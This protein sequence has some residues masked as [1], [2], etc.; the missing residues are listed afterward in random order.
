MAVLLR[1][2]A[3]PGVTAGTIYAVRAYV[4]SFYEA[5]SELPERLQNAVCVGDIVN[6]LAG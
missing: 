5:T 6:R 4:F 2:T 1:L 3:M